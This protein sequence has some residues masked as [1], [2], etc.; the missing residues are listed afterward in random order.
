MSGF[1]TTD[2]D[3]I[4]DASVGKATYKGAA[5]YFL[6]LLTEAALP[7][8]TGATIAEATYT[9]HARIAMKA[10]EWTVAAEGEHH[11]NVTK[12]FP[13]CTAGENVIVGWALC[14]KKEKGEAG[15][16]VKSGRVPPTVVKAG[17]E[18]E[19][20]AGTLSFRLADTA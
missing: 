20:L 18:P 8:D 17:I 6:A 11:N 9:G 5:E 12:T 1:S 4:L 7:G 2:K 14:E 19:F 16:I 13:E 10:T 3:E 15:K